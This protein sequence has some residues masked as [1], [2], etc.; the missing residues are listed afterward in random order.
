MFDGMHKLHKGIDNT[1]RFKIKDIMNQLILT[2]KTVIWKMYDPKVVKTYCLDIRCY[3]M[4]KKV[5]AH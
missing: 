4:L 3:K 2:N 1:L 5:Y